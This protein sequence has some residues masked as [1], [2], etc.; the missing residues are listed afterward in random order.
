MQVI[1]ASEAK[2]AAEKPP[3]PPVDVSCSGP[4]TF[5]FVRYVAS[6]DRDVNLVQANPN[7]PSDQLACTR[8]DM[9]F[10]PKP[11]AERCRAADRG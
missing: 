8:L 7:G 4:F 3:K 6:L 11:N 9:H 5:D 1:D 2:L 10:A